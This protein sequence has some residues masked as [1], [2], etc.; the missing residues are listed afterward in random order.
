MPASWDVGSGEVWK[1]G[2]NINHYQHNATII[3]Y[4]G[5][6][7]QLKTDHHIWKKYLRINMT[8]SMMRRNLI[9]KYRDPEFYARLNQDNNQEKFIG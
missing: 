7:L 6:S 8:L 4:N 5:L 1:M 2:V 9:K 3:S